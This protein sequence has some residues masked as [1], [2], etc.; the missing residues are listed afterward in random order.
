M[1][2]ISSPSIPAPS[3]S[4]VTGR[5]SAALDRACAAGR[6]KNLCRRVRTSCRETLWDTLGHHP[7]QV[8]QNQLSCSLS[9]SLVQTVFWD[10]WDTWDTYLTK[11]T[12][13]L[14][15]DELFFWSPAATKTRNGVPSVPKNAR[16]GK[17][18]HESRNF[19]LG[20]GPQTAV[21]KIGGVTKIGRGRAARERKN[22]A[23][24]NRRAREQ[25]VD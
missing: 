1:L 15:P 19:F 10:T 22:L 24:E 3:A 7:S 23:R 11:H 14:F 17:I 16:H 20:N 9:L 4:G 18:T 12:G 13:K 8:S 2:A 6:K 25:R 5:H 21:K